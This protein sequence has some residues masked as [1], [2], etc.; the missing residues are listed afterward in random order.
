L[1]NARAKEADQ[2]MY[3]AVI[4]A[5]IHDG[6]EAKKG[7]DEQVLPMLK[8]AAGFV[9]AYFVR[10]DDTHGI[11]VQVFETEEQARGNAPP[12][13]TTAPGVTLA[14]QQFGEVIGSA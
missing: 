3:A 7:L 5:D 8:Q 14:S 9:G 6:A 1:G 13:G 4:H 10:L 2:T 11:S 12:V